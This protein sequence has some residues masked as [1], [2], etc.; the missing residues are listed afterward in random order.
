VEPETPWSAS[1]A[2]KIS[3]MEDF[4]PPGSHFSTPEHFDPLISL[5][6]N[7]LGCRVKSD[8]SNILVELLVSEL[9]S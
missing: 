9:A 8:D 6:Y 3:L 5:W 4:A 2:T 7:P 1:L